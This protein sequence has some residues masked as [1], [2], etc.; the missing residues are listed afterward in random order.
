MKRRTCGHCDEPLTI[1]RTDGAL[2]GTVGIGC[3]G[4]GSWGEV[5]PHEPR[6]RPL[7]GRDAEW[8]AI[9]RADTHREA[10]GSVD[11]PPHPGSLCRTCGAD[12]APDQP[13]P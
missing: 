5:L 9:S 4:R 13:C 1:D 6:P 7:S 11:S 10:P 12:H 2:V 8:A 3:A